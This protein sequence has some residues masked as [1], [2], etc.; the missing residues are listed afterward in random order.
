MPPTAVSRSST[1]TGW[2]STDKRHAA[3]MP[4]GP[5]P[6]IT[7]GSV[8]TPLASFF[9]RGFLGDDKVIEV[10]RKRQRPERQREALDDPE[11]GAQPLL[12]SARRRH[13][14]MIGISNRK[15]HQQEAAETHGPVVRHHD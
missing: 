8:D 15:F 2:P 13:R 10:E 6:R 7:I 5:P 4:A 12:H 14:Q 3:A 1:T 9:A 11:A